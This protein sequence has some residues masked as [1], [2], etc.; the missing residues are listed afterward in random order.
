MNSSRKCDDAMLERCKS[1]GVLVAVTSRCI[2]DTDGPMPYAETRRYADKIGPHGPYR[3]ENGVLIAPSGFPLKT[4]DYG[5]S[6]CYADENPMNVES[7]T[8]SD[9]L[10]KIRSK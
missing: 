3:R 8:L 5:V 9:A 7:P 6:W 10:W 1:V 4:E 2:F